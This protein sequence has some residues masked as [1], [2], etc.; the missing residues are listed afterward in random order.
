MPSSS[1]YPPQ[2]QPTQEGSCAECNYEQTQQRLEHA[3]NEDHVIAFCTEDTP[4]LSNASSL[5][6]LTESKVMK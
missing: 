1:N 6:D 5:T 2:Y 3:T 4:F